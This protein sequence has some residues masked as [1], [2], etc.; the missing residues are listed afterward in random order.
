MLIKS[1]TEYKIKSPPEDAISSVKFGPNTNQFLLVSSWDSSVRLYDVTTNNLRH[2]YSHEAPVLDCCF[3]DAV[4]SYSGGLDNILKTFDFNTTSESTVGTHSNAIRCVEYCSEVNGIITGSWDHH[5]KLWDPRTSLCNGS[6]NQGDKVYT[7]S[8][9]GEKIVVG[10]AGRKILVWDIRNM[11]YTL[12]KRESSLKYQTRAIR[13]FPNKQGFVL[14]SIEGRVAVE[15]LDTNPEIQKK[16]YA[17]KCHRIKEDGLEKIYP[18]NAI[19]FHPTHNTFAT[20]GSDGYVN[21]WDGFNKKRLCQFHQ[22]HTSVT[23]LS[24]SHN[25]SILAIACSYFLNEDNPPTPLPEDTIYIR[26][27]TDQET[28]PKFSAS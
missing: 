24:F 22:Y 11:A 3:T 20:G 17:F 18:V 9:C 10:T 14:S 23:S 28:K 27:V 25:G 16:K 7:M 5:L 2:K 6:Y 4:H 12:Q 21:I 15:Y 19:S 26:T 13:C 1:Q 8:V